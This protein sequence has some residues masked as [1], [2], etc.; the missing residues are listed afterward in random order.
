MIGK[1]S[2]FCE[3]FIEAGWLVALG[4]V[5]LYVSGA[6]NQGYAVAKAYFLRVVVPLMVVAWAVKLWEE[7]EDGGVRRHLLF[8]ASFWKTPLALPVAGYVVVVLLTAL[9][10][11]APRM[12]FYGSFERLQGAYTTLAYAAFFCLVAAHL[13][14]REQFDRLIAV[15]ILSSIPVCLYALAQQSGMDPARYA[16]S[17]DTLMWA[18]RSTMG[19]HL[20]LG[21][22][23]IMVMPWTL[24]KLFE[25]ALRYLR[26]EGPGDSAGNGKGWLAAG[27]LVAQNLFMT[28]FLLYGLS[29]PLLWWMNLPVLAAYMGLLIW[30]LQLNAKSHPLIEVAGYTVLLSLQGV[31]LI[32]THARGPW[33]GALAAAAVF[34][35]LISLRWRMRRLLAGVVAGAVL[36]ILFVGLLNIPRGPLEPLKRRHPVFARLGSLS[37]VAGSVSFRLRLWPSVWRLVWTDP[38]LRPADSLAGIRPLIGYGPETLGLVVERTLDRQLAAREEPWA[39]I[40]DRAHNDLLNHLAENGLIG[41]AAFLLLIGAFAR[42]GLKALWREESPRQQLYLTAL[43][44]AMAGH[45]VELQFGIGVTSTRFLFWLFLA[46]AVVLARPL[47]DSEPEQPA[48]GP[49]LWKSWMVRYALYVALAVFVIV[50]VGLRST[51]SITGVYV[52]LLVALAGMVAGIVLPALEFGPLRGDRRTTLRD[53]GVY[54]VVLG[55]AV[56]LIYRLSFRGQAA[57]TIF[58]LG[59]T[60]PKE[61]VS[62]FQQAAILEPNES[63]YQIALGRFLAQ[64]GLILFTEKPELKPPEGFK[65]DLALARTI[66]IDTLLRMGAE[67]VMGLAEASIREA[68]RLDPLDG[69]Y[70]YLLGRL[71]HH[72][73]LRGDKARL[74][75]AIRY[76]R[77]AA[78]MSPSRP[79]PL[80]HVALAYLGKGQPKEALEQI[81]ALQARGYDSWSVHYALAQIYHRTGKPELALEE[82]KKAMASAPKTIRSMLPKLIEQGKLLPAPIPGPNMD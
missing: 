42:L 40:K 14:R 53:L 4:L 29:H 17:R 66:R 77:E 19:H 67:G 33:L 15:L 25:T 63:A 57:D 56:I 54:A 72:W 75:V 3:R 35:F 43:L 10:S 39:R 13:K 71:N 59:Q 79:S 48:A 50:T 24:A 73:G 37:T 51:F 58:T 31:A 70:A 36:A 78:E 27:S 74:D 30:T 38:E 55:V 82:E 45:L 41:L 11:V 7:R 69:R 62:A 8:F 21:A 65:P 16:G 5:Q 46:F 12:S 49:S 20:F 52:S 23:L 2:N 32:A 47:P 81:L 68:R 64:I 34:G 1:L 6:S 9:T 18:A 28:F 26:Q 22:Y 76:Y 80:V 61:S 60:D 44:A